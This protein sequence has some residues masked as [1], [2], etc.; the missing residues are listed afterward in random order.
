M[1]VGS[2]RVLLAAALVATGLI[3]GG[4]DSL[5]GAQ[6][7]IDPGDL[8]NDLATRLDRAGQ[9][10]Y[11]AEYQLTGGT[12]ATIARQGQ[13]SR[14]AYTYPGGK[15]IIGPEG[16][17]DC[18]DSGPSATCTVTPLASP[19]PGPS[20]ALLN[21]LGQHGMIAPPIVAGL[22]TATALDADASVS[23]RDDTIAGQHANCLK[24]AS[25]DNAAA[26][27]F[28]VCLTTDGVVGSFTGVLNGTRVE[29]ALTQYRGSVDPDAFDAPKTARMVYRG[30][31]G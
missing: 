11:T 18:R 12:H 21:Q 15:L 20:A 4:C 9:L 31:G 23:Q 27:D 8:V 28:E 19:D 22:L 25:V 29:L 14:V 30:A 3:G 6:G 5:D 2:R 7:A 16:Y 10:T 1:R 13:P 17:T 26:S 24:V